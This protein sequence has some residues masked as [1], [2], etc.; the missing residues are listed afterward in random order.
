MVVEGRFD[1][2]TDVIF[3]F[4]PKTWWP[5][6]GVRRDPPHCAVLVCDYAGPTENAHFWANGENG[7]S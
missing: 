4:T 3:L 6:R 1:T 2:Y 7:L 5:F